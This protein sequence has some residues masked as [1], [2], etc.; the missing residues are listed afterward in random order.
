MKASVFVILFPFCLAVKIKLENYTNTFETTFGCLQLSTNDGCRP[1]LS[2]NRFKHLR[3]TVNNVTIMR[4][5]VMAAEGP[6]IRL[7]K[8]EYPVDAK[9]NEIVLSAWNNT[10]SEMRSY[11]RKADGT[12]TDYQLLKRISTPGMLSRFYPMLFTMEIDQNGVVKLV[13]DGHRVP[14]VEFQDRNL[15]FNYVGFCT[16]KAPATFFFDCPLV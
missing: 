12:L 15:S 6:H 7:S 8:I 4:M 14:L 3:T 2:T 10:A 9:I 5:G 13:K 11:V 1:Y 16:Y